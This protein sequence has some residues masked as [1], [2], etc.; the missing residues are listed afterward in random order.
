MAEDQRQANE[1]R[2]LNS[3]DF[4]HSRGLTFNSFTTEPRSPRAY[5]S[6]L[7][8]TRPFPTEVR[9]DVK[10]WRSGGDLAAT[11]LL[12]FVP[13]SPTQH[14]PNLVFRPLASTF[15]SCQLSFCGVPSLTYPSPR[16]CDPEGEDWQSN[17]TR[18]PP[19][20][21]RGDGRW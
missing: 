2:V 15:L 20:E 13:Y 8:F 7:F 19:A 14:F 4:L 6:F 21:A 11:L 1:Y 3:P 5:N 17:A 12:L 18:T 9:S 10:I 16:N